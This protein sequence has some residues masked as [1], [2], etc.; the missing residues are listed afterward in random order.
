MCTD[1]GLK[2]GINLDNFPMLWNIDKIF[3]MLEDLIATKKATSHFFLFMQ[4]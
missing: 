2:Y 1:Y 3:G 4:K